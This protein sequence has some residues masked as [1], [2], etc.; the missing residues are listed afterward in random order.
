MTTP[1]TLRSFSLAA[2]LGAAL[3]IENLRSVGGLASSDWLELVPW[4]LKAYA[5]AEQSRRV[6][7]ACRAAGLGIRVHG[8]QLGAGPGVRLAAELGAASVDHVNY[9]A[10]AD[11]TALEGMR[12]GLTKAR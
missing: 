6:L 1:H 7:E 2:A 8:N 4:F 10:P 3:L 11:V 12:A 9:L 5:G